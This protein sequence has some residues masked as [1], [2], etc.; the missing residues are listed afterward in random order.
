M[1]SGN[2][3]YTGLG[4][5]GTSGIKGSLF[6]ILPFALFMECVRSLEYML[7]VFLVSISV[8]PG[9]FCD[10]LDVLLIT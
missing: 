10:K 8:L 9:I 4:W 6:D 1:G 2:G 3:L 5:K 7:F